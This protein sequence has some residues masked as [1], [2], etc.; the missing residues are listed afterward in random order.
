MSVSIVRG[1]PVVAFVIC[2][3]LVSGPASA[4]GFAL[5]EQSASGLGNAY[6]GIAAAA[7]DAST[8]F[9][10]PAGMSKLGPG[11]RVS[12]AA[13]AI[14]PNTQFRDGASTAAAGGRPLGSDGGDAGDPALVP[15]AYFVTDLGPRLSFGLGINVPFGLATEYTPDWIGR[16]QGIRSEIKTLNVN[17]SVSWKASDRLSLGFGVNWQRGEISLLTGVNAPPLPEG[18]NQVDVD[19]DGF[20]WNAGLL[21]DLTPATRIGVA[22]R[23]SIEYHLEGTTRFSGIPAAVQAATPALRDGNVRLDVDTPDM[24]SISVAH[25]LDRW[26]LLGDVTWTGWGNIKSLPLVRDTGAVQDTLRF[27]FKDTMR[28]SLGASYRMNDAWTVR[29]GIAF[30]ESPVPNAEDRSVRLPDND[31][32]WIS[33]G[34]R[35]SLGTTGAL[36]VGY[37]FVKIKDAAINNNQAAL[38]RGTVNGNYKA[39]VNIV[40]VQYSRGF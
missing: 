17:P 31:R 39:D 28:Y 23:S 13:H 14:M 36:D 21:F 16:F 6:A 29:T 18:R 19:D 27:N 22:Y 9:W 26:T 5:W 40:S 38:G 20:G 11:R 7:E 37:A 2:S 4:A 12:L 33:F 34:A 3:S 32:T 10:N 8:V 24:L 25:Q 35:Y 1:R 15:N 30:D